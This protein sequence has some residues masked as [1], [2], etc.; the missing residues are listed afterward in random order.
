M[1]G[2]GWKV[3]GRGDDLDQHRFKFRNH[4]HGELNVV[5]TNYWTNSPWVTMTNFTKLD[6]GLLQFALTNTTAWDF[7]V[8]VSTNVGTN[9][10]FLRTAYPVYQFSD[11]SNSPQR[12]YRLTWP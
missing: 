12:F 5:L 10:S 2:R 4:W 7:S 11:P 6:N 1:A 8:L 3:A 9:W